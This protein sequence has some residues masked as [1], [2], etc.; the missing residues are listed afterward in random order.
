MTEPMHY[1]LSRLDKMRARA[2]PGNWESGVSGI[3]DS[4]ERYV[5]TSCGDEHIL[6]VNADLIVAEHN[7]GPRRDEMLARAQAIIDEVIEH[8]FQHDYTNDVCECRLCDTSANHPE[9]INHADDCPVTLGRTWL[10]EYK[11]A[12]ND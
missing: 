6:F 7:S 10:A 3:W 8:T 4:E 5:A 2:A 1:T 9:D 11:G 12:P